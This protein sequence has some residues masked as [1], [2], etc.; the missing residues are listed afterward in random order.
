M[1]KMI[2]LAAVAALAGCAGVGS[3]GFAHKGRVVLDA[4]PVPAL[5][6]EEYGYDDEEGEP[7]MKFGARGGLVLLGGGV[8]PRI[9]VGG[10]GRMFESEAGRV[11]VS[12]ELT[13]DLANIDRNNMYFG[14][15]ADYVGFISDLLYWKA[16]GVGILEMQ[17]DKNFFIM[18]IEGGVGLWFPIGGEDEEEST[19]AAVVNFMLQIPVSVAGGTINSPVM[20]A[21][22]GGYEF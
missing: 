12:I 1:R 14:F 10:Y 5:S 7:F 11:E 13:P 3:G 17:G 19:T 20:F 21:I 16:G 18:A 22:T 15:G 4:Q 8:S 6:G 2:V 9:T